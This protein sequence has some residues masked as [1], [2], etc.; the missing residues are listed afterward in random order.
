MHHLPVTGLCEGKLL[1]F[2]RVCKLFM[3]EAALILLGEKMIQE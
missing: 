2:F 3:A 1:S